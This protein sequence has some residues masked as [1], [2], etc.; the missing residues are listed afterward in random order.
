MS[1]K[2]NR[3]SRVDLCVVR[4]KEKSKTQSFVPFHFAAVQQQKSTSETTCAFIK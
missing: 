1:A 2:I 3:P 4:L